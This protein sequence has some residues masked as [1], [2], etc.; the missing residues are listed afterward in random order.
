MPEFT[1][2]NGPPDI[3]QAT[4]T[5]TGE[6]TN[7]NKLTSRNDFIE[8]IP[9]IR[10]YSVERFYMIVT[11]Y[12]SIP[13]TGIYTFT[14][15]APHGSKLIFYDPYDN[16]KEIPILS[17]WGSEACKA[18]NPVKRKI[19]NLNEQIYG[20]RLEVYGV[21]RYGFSFTYKY[22]NR[23]IEESDLDEPLYYIPFQSSIYYY[24]NY[25]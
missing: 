21:S 13:S 20:F 10:E 22:E 19:I 23:K 7:T 12:V 3:S 25:Y 1:C 15:S 8:Q 16:Y 4:L 2:T 11:G 9:E 5:F 14:L 18:N 24:Y 6:L 17:Y